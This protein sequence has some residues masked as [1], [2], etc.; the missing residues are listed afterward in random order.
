[1]QLV[2]ERDRPDP[3]RLADLRRLI[4]TSTAPS[5]SPTPLLEGLPALP[6]AAVHE[7]V[8]FADSPVESGPW[9]PPL[10]ILAHAA[11][12]VLA[13][14]GGW[15]FW[16]GRSVWPRP[17]VLAGEG[18]EGGKEGEGGKTGL[19][20]RSVFVDAAT[21]AERV[22]AADLLLRCPAVAAVVADGSGFA[23][24][25][26]RR[27]QLAAQGGRATALLARPP[28]E[29]KE[30]SAAATR[31][32]VRPCPSPTDCPR[33]TV[34]LLRCKGVQPAPEAPRAWA[35]EWDHE[36]RALVVPADVVHR[37]GQEVA[38]AP[39]RGARSA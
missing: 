9:L 1:M 18:G 31:W 38:A 34:E 29:L 7:W 5:A 28:W 10:C 32:L 20:E 26:T 2:E 6:A 35:V 30:L 24:P 14:A 33:W 19:L 25:H 3:V 17:W 39:G 22:W 21:L 13:A 12:R 4:H 11:A 15:V 37:S 16:V 27:L 8:G 23:M 36:R